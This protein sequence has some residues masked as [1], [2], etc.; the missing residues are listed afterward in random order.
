MLMNHSDIFQGIFS[1]KPLVVLITGVSGSGKDTIVRKLEEKGLP[2]H[3]VVTTTSRK[4][5]DQEQNGV[6]YHFVTNVEFMRMIRDGEF[7]EFAQVYDEYKGV[8]YIHIKDAMD[9]GKDIIFRLDVQGV[10]RMKEVFP[11]AVT[12]FIIPND[13]GE[14][15]ERLQQRCTESTEKIQQRLETGRDEILEINQYDYVLVNTTGKLEV[16]VNDLQAI[17]KA[18]HHRVKHRNSQL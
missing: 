2:I 4:P 12:I 18:E 6:D 10:R 15:K 11:E 13:E 14:W 1:P 3:F 9:S 5:R 17:L 8:Q 7:I 16:A